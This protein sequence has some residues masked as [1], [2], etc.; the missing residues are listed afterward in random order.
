MRPPAAEAAPSRGA[1]PPR[2]TSVVGDVKAGL[3]RLGRRH[4]TGSTRVPTDGQAIHPASNPCPE[5]REVAPA[6]HASRGCRSICP[7]GPL[8]PGSTGCLP[9]GRPV[10][11]TRSDPAEASSPCDRRSPGP[12]RPSA[13]NTVGPTPAAAAARSWTS[14]LALHRWKWHR[15]ANPGDRSDRAPRARGPCPRELA[16]AS[17][18]M[19]LWAHRLVTSRTYWPPD[20]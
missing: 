13:R 19:A 9:R 3:W 7:A 8:S 16:A 17:D 14:D 11:V 6:D 2:R 15:L 10:A 1:R 4:R 20:R 18:T 5:R 12:H